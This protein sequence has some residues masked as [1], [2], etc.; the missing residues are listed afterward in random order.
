MIVLVWRRSKKLKADKNNMSWI[1]GI[2]WL[3][4]QMADLNVVMSFERT[5]CIYKS[6]Y[7]LRVS[8][9]QEMVP[10]G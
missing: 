10:G 7:C 6:N 8:P 4:L 2:M 9:V 1:Y 5:F 3:R